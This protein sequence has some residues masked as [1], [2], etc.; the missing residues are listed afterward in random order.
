MSVRL[1]PIK[2]K[3][4][5]VGAVFIFAKIANPCLNV[6]INNLALIRT[7]FVVIETYLCYLFSAGLATAAAPVAPRASVG[8]VDPQSP[9]QPQL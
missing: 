8:V 4:F 3:V 1:A 7:C 6:L 2:N 5:L 9:H